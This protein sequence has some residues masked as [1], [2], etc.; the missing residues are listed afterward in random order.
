MEGGKK[1]AASF[2]RSGYQ[3]DWN[4]IFPLDRLREMADEMMSMVGSGFI[5]PRDV[6]TRNKS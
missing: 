1:M 5:A 6:I 2:D 4:V 3:R